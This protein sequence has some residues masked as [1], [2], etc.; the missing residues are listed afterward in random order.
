VASRSEDPK[1]ITRVIKSNLYAHSTSA[2]YR[3]TD[4]RTDGRLTIAITRFALPVRES[5]GK[6][7]LSVRDS[8]Q[9][10]TKENEG[11]QNEGVARL[12]FTVPTSTENKQ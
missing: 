11:C 5:R 10:K 12:V 2:L 8:E 9:G 4:T 1:L 7:K 3:R 6:K